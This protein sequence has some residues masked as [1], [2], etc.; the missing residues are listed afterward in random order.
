MLQHMLQHMQHM[1]QWVCV[2]KVDQKFSSDSDSAPNYVTDPVY[3][4]DPDPRTL[5]LPNPNPNPT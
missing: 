4:T 5:T 3:V 2:K 1:Q